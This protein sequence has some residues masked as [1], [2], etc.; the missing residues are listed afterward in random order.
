[1]LEYALI[2][3]VRV[4]DVLALLAGVGGY[5]SA[6][7]AAVVGTADAVVMVGRDQVVRAAR[8]A[9]L[10]FVGLEGGWAIS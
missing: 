4:V 6:A 5:A 9:C 10:V 8:F 3:V 1:M 7:G 2:V